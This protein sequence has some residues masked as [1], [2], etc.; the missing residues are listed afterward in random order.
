[1]PP[2][3]EP[4]LMISPPALDHA[5]APRSPVLRC[6]NVGAKKACRSRLGSWPRTAK[7]VDAGIADQISTGPFSVMALAIAALCPVVA[8][9]QSAITGTRPALVHQGDGRAHRVSP[10]R[11]RRGRALRPLP[12]NLLRGCSTDPLAAPGDDDADFRYPF[13]VPQEM[14][15]ERSRGAFSDRNIPA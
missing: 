2:K 13:F 1:M 12:A 9:I 7:M 11:A 5:R 15:A 8:A 4:I 14:S 6:R 3:T 10:G